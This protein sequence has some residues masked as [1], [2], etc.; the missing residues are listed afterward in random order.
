MFHN[1]SKSQGKCGSFG[2]ALDQIL[3]EFGS[4]DYTCQVAAYEPIVLELW[5]R[6]T[7]F[8]ATAIAT[9]RRC[10]QGVLECL[11]QAAVQ[12]TA[13]RQQLGDLVENLRSLELHP[14]VVMESG[15]PECYNYIKEQ[16]KGLTR[17]ST[18]RSVLQNIKMILK[19][20]LKYS[21]TYVL[22]LKHKREQIRDKLTVN[23]SVLVEELDNKLNESIQDE[24]IDIVEK[25]ADKLHCYELIQ[26]HLDDTQKSQFKEICRICQST[27]RV[28]E[29]Y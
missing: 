5:E 10:Q 9:L 16:L 12:Q 26:D 29:V 27:I 14:R 18:Y 21:N 25:Q 4:K 20:M 24:I 7:N 11:M 1:R 2:K 13:T 23:F 19:R 6:S 28:D 3:S 8:A 15:V 22:Y 17:P